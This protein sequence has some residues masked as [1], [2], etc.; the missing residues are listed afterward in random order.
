[1]LTLPALFKIQKAA[2]FGGSLVNNDVLAWNSS[3]GKFE[4]VAPSALGLTLEQLTDVSITSPAQG[5]VIYFNGTN[6]VALGPAASG[7]FLKC[8][9]ASANPS[10]AVPSDATYSF[11][12]LTDSAIAS[13][14]QGDV[15]YCNGS[16]WVNLGHGT[17]GQVLTTN[18]ASANPSWTTV[19]GTAYS[20][21]N[22]TDSGITSPAKGDVIYFNGTSWV[23]LGHGAVNQVLTQT[24]VGGNY[25]P[26]WENAYVP[27][28]E[29]LSDSGITGEA[30]GD[31]IYFNGSSWVNLTHGT[32]GQFL[33][34]NGASA[35]PSWANGPSFSFE[36]LTDSGITSPAQGDV[37]YYNGS[38]WVNLGHGTAGNP[39]ITGGASANPSYASGVTIDSHGRLT[40]TAHVGTV[41]ALT[42]G[43]TVTVNA[44]LGDI[45]TGTLTAN[46]TLAYSNFVAGQSVF[47][48][49]TQA[50]SG[51]P[52]TLT[53]QSGTKKTGSFTTSTGASAIDHYVLSYDGT[54]Y[55]FD[56]AGQNYS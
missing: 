46:A 16:H 56:V 31:I 47:L 27:S 5:S 34:T 21:E 37:I 33:K 8:N 39:L 24:D 12:T 7:T 26:A 45:F 13:P 48:Y 49:I 10:W 19:S 29:S 4:L 18:G 40:A 6:W 32:S 53:P 30:Q 42:M 54:N 50:A 9:G 25:L 35:N 11:E 43:S 14:A 20:F 22:L 28:F 15:I 3:A 51:G 55:Y 41:S 2:D 44:Q 52:Y 23:N 1:M 17:S 38:S 36:T